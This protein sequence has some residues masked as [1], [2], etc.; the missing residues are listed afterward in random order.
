M[1]YEITFYT[2]A[3]SKPIW[4][5]LQSWGHVAISPAWRHAKIT[6]KADTSG[7]GIVGNITFAID[8]KR[9]QGKT[10]GSRQMFRLRWYLFPY[11]TVGGHH[12]I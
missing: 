5:A 2:L 4:G 3:P 10:P 1:L 7:L 11:K 8:P 9:K 6:H 12:T